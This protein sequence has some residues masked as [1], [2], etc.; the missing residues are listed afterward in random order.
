MA[1]EVTARRWDV[2]CAAVREGRPRHRKVRT[3]GT[4]RPGRFALYGSNNM[5]HW[6]T[7]TRITVINKVHAYEQGTRYVIHHVCS[8]TAPKSPESPR[9]PKAEPHAGASLIRANHRHKTGAPRAG[10]SA[11]GA[12]AWRA[13]RG[14]VSRGIVRLL[15]S[16]RTL[17]RE[18]K[19]ELAPQRAGAS[20]EEA[21]GPLPLVNLPQ[22]TADSP[23]DLLVDRPLGVADRARGREHQPP[24][25]GDSWGEVEGEG[26]EGARGRGVKV[27]SSTASS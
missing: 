27:S 8:P 15:D 11:A 17:G 25:E 5:V 22:K 1:S 26:E 6:H 3:L 19:E 20:P 13:S 14:T 24:G 23:V 21:E 2:V 4:Q 7:N 16:L 12:V 18:K 9:G 10:S